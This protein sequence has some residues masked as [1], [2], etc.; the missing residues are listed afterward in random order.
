MGI[1]SQC[2]SVYL[3]YMLKFNHTCNIPCVISAITLQGYFS[4]CTLYCA[5]LTNLAKVLPSTISLAIVH[6]SCLR[7]QNSFS[8]QFPIDFLYGKETRMNFIY[9][10]SNKINWQN[11]KEIMECL[12]KG[13]YFKAVLHQHVENLKEKKRITQQKQLCVSRKRTY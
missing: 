3:V 11:G 8:K 9:I 4:S 5:A 12:V 1:I 6:L 10:E 2:A 13:H 7:Y